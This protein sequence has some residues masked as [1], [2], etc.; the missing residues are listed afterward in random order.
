VTPRYFVESTCF[1]TDLFNL[2]LGVLSTELRLIILL[3]YY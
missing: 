3:L 2:Y 1:I